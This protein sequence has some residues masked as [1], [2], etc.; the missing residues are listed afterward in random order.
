VNGAAARPGALLPTLVT[1]T[2]LAQAAL[3]ARAIWWFGRLPERF[4][5]H[6]DGAGN[7]DRWTERGIASWFGLALIPL[8]IVIFLGAIAVFL[9]PLT[10]SAPALV[11]VPRKD[12]FLRLSPAGRARI[13]RPTQAFL[14][15]TAGLVSVLFLYIHDGTARVAVGEWTVLPVWPVFAFLAGVMLPLPFYWVATKRTIERAAREEGV[16]AAGR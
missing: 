7:P 1:F 10:N 11:N 2:L 13:A 3:W 16:E 15:W 9:A 12:L 14:C 5:I 4:P 6:F 8:G